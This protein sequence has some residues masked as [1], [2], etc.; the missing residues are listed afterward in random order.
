MG[1]SFLSFPSHSLNKYLSR[2]FHVAGIIFS[3]VDKKRTE[4][5][6]GLALLK[7][8]S[9]GRRR[10]V[11]QPRGGCRAG[12]GAGSLGPA[13][14]S[15]WPRGI[16]LPRSHGK[17]DVSETVNFSSACSTEDFFRRAISRYRQY[18][19]FLHACNFFFP[20]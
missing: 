6:Q 18:H 7:L 3:T 12:P 2:D 19:I 8:P 10:T 15:C 16:S 11:S 14:L 20:F 9:N 1:L 13:P 5:L 4:S 17:T